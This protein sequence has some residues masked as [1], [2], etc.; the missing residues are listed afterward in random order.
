MR[1]G[2]ITSIHEARKSLLD[3][4]ARGVN[5]VTIDVNADFAYQAA[6]ELASEGVGYFG[7]VCSRDHSI[8]FIF[9]PAEQ[10][11]EEVVTEED[12]ERDYSRYFVMVV[13]REEPGAKF[14]ETALPGVSEFRDPTEALQ[15]H[16]EFI[17][18]GR[19]DRVVTMFQENNGTMK[20]IRQSGRFLR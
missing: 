15:K 18:E 8:E 11:E 17:G 5:V 4:Q 16:S 10:E 3:T 12:L 1:E 20:I 7:S 2:P 19:I 6:K 9:R 14:H 13:L